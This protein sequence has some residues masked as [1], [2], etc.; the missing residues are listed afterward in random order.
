[1]TK[2]ANKKR[3]DVD[4]QEGDM[5]YLKLRPHRQNSICTRVFQ[6][7]AARFYGPFKIKKKVGT[8]AYRLQLPEGSRVHP[9]FH[10]SCLKRAVGNHDVVIRLPDELDTDLFMTF[11]PDEVLAGRIKHIAVQPYQQLLIRWKGRTDEEATWENLGDFQRQFP[12]F[13]LEDKAI[14]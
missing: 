1:M 7:L 12:E 14:F 10:V 9:V 13:R 2:Q 8:V 11:E 6:K 3:R 5:V 4:F